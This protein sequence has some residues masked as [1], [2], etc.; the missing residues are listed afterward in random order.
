MTAYIDY[1][2]LIRVDI[3]LPCFNFRRSFMT[4]RFSLTPLFRH[5]VGFDHFNDFF[6]NVF[7]RDD[8]SSSSYP[9]YNIEK[10]GE[11][12]Y[13]ITMAV[14]GFEES[15]ID[16]NVK[17]D[18][19]NVVGRIQDKE[20]TDEVTYLHR[21]IATRAFE[22]QFRLANHVRVKN[23]QLKHGLLRIELERVI[24]KAEEIQKIAINL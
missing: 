8:N 5:S 24:P 10:L 3:H 13:F 18:I 17:K 1:R 23:A 12:Q 22:R 4:S 19:L 15:D 21:G 7:L 16:V 2:C 20:Q 14:A 6:E 11:D 9:P